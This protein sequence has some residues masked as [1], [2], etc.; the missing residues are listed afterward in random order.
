M[1]YLYPK[2][3]PDLVK[4]M[5]TYQKEPFRFY[6]QFSDL[7]DFYLLRYN[8]CVKEFDNSLTGSERI[9]VS[10]FIR[11]EIAF[12]RKRFFKPMDFCNTNIWIYQIT[13]PC[14]QSK[15]VYRIGLT[16]HSEE[17][18]RI[19]LNNLRLIFLNIIN[20]FILKSNIWNFKHWKYRR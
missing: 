11:L 6:D 7:C 17:H 19:F 10:M 5:Q 12:W 3:G 14:N 18:V 8:H 20:C 1:N 15:T 4:D 9:F 16:I 2:S 13:K